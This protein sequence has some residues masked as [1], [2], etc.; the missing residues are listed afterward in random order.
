MTVKQIYSSLSAEVILWL[1]SEDPAVLYVADEQVGS[2]ELGVL[3]A[4][5]EELIVDP[6]TVADGVNA[7]L[8]LADRYHRSR[9][10]NLEF[11]VTIDAEG[12]LGFEADPVVVVEGCR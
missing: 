9:Q 12:V 10:V 8:V 3:W 2:V 11:G 5:V 4:Q 1:F 6:E 7:V